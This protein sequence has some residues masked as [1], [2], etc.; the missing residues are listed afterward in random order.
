MSSLQLQSASREQSIDVRIE[1]LGGLDGAGLV[2]HVG[3]RRHELEAFTHG[4]GSGWLHIG[5]RVVV[6]HVAHRGPDIEVWM[7]GRRY[8]LQKARRAPSRSGAP[9]PPATDLRAPMPGTVLRILVKPGDAVAA[10]QALVVLESMKMEL[11]LSAASTATV[12]EVLCREGELVQM[13]QVLIRFEETAAAAG[14]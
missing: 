11:T 14:A 3:P 9:A 5:G 10:H 2:I 12:A 13:G 8:R 1:R 6:Y 4:P 7:D